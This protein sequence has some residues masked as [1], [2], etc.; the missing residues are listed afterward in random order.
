MASLSSRVGAARASVSTLRRGCVTARQPLP[1]LSEHRSCPSRAMSQILK[2]QHPCRWG[3]SPASIRSNGPTDAAIPRWHICAPPP[4]WPVSGEP[5]QQRAGLLLDQ[6][7]LPVLGLQEALGNHLVGECSQAVEVAVDIQQATGLAVQA[8]PA[9][10]P[11]LEQLLHGA[12]PAGQSEERIRQLSHEG[13]ALMQVL[14]NVQLGQPAMGDLTV[15]EL[16]RDDANGLPAS[17]TASASSPIRPT[18]PPP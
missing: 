2:R 6:Q 16:L 18:L 3:I 15:D 17:S 8:E 4:P 10:A 1:T 12:D 13:L 14:D 7:H 5:I 9:P 11:H